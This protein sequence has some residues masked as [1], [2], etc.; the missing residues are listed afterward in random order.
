MT[1]KT[2]LITRLPERPRSWEFVKTYSFFALDSILTSK[3]GF[4]SKI[5]KIQEISNN[6]K[7]ENSNFRKKTNAKTCKNRRNLPKL[8]KFNNLAQIQQNCRNS[9][10]CLIASSN[11]KNWNSLLRGGWSLD[12]DI[13]WATLARSAESYNSAHAYLCLRTCLPGAMSGH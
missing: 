7:L 4:E 12:P 3:T 2:R 11:K 9:T 5:R 10:N 1:S 13:T 8:H 6:S